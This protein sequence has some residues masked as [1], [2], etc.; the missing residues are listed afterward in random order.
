MEGLTAVNFGPADYALSLNLPIRYS[1]DDKEVEGRLDLLVQRAHA[2][3]IYVMAPVVP[4]TYENAERLWKK[5]VD[6]LI[7]GNDLYHFNQG[8]RSV[9]EQAIDKLRPNG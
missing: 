7:M 4:P 8:C 5:G 6:M 9:R 1:M 2:R 3:G